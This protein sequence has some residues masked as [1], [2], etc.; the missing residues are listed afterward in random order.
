[1]SIAST[2]RAAIRRA[3]PADDPV[4]VALFRD[5]HAYN[6]SLDP[7][8]ALADGW[9]TLLAEH[10]A[11]E[12]QHGHGA[13]FLATVGERPAGLLMMEGHT[14]APLF[15]ERY[16]AEI[17]A[18]YVIPALRGSGLADELIAGGV[19]WARAHG[20]DRIQLYVT[21]SNVAAKRFYGRTGFHAIQE[22]WCRDLGFV[23][24]E[25]EED[26]ACEATY[27]Q[28]HNLLSGSRHRLAIDDMPHKEDQPPFEDELNESVDINA[29]QRSRG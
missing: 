23:S 16:W 13:T 18:L 22:I 4:V 15:R 14:D 8:F 28:G 27:A 19:A 2:Q 29:S 3:E 25:P 7:R 6:A 5:L 20:Y 21:A 11:Y 10:L 24:G 26:P 9:D 17:V 1:M 12:R